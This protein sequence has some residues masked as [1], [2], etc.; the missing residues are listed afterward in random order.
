M[1]ATASMPETAPLPGNVAVR[2]RGIF[3]LVRNAG[4]AFTLAAAIALPVLHACGAAAQQPVNSQAL[5]T[6]PKGEPFDLAFFRTLQTMLLAMPEGTCYERSRVGPTPIAFVGIPPNNVYFNDAL[7]SQINEFSKSSIKT[8]LPLALSI[9]DSATFAT[10]A[11]LSTVNTEDQ[12]KLREALANIRNA[13][14]VVVLNAKRP[15]RDLAQIRIE[16]F[17]RSASGAQDCPNS[18]EFFVRLDNFN[19]IPRT[20]V[21]ARF[22]GGEYVDGAF[23]FRHALRKSTP[24]IKDFEQL[25]VDLDLRMAGACRFAQ[26]AADAFRSEYFAVGGEQGGAVQLQGTR[27]PSLRL[28]DDDPLVRDGETAG[29]AARTGTEG[30]AAP[31]GGQMRLRLS[32]FEGYND[33]VDVNL[34]V[35]ERRLQRYATFFRMI[36]TPADL[37][38]C[39][40]L[41]N[42]P[43][44]RLIQEARS[45]PAGPRLSMAKP[46]LKVNTDPLEIEIAMRS[47]RH[48]YC[49]VLDKNLEAYVVYPWRT[50]QLEKPLER[51][52]SITYPSG[53]TYEPAGESLGGRP[54]IYPQATRE[55]FGCFSSS[56]RLPE[57]VENRWIDLHPRNTG[58]KGEHKALSTLEVKSV[59]RQ[60]RQ[61]PGVSESYVWIDVVE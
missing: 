14:L 7:K 27:W 41:S 6:L 3:D 1:S 24:A 18:E 49:W 55:L 43:L 32:L 4:A 56:E 57:A 38:G 17:S 26:T 8:Y 29:G 37:E 54:I 40:A 10:I 25:E 9:N 20:Q 22:L 46:R 44:E 2:Q 5:S 42:D 15:D 51:D 39:R 31:K 59:L 47:D 34:D 16:V 13:P 61:L 33:V 48:I 19:V 23:A 28:G 52:R 30:A 11:A 45:E 50:E 35:T 60:L 12:L 21:D 36:A 53:F 58:G